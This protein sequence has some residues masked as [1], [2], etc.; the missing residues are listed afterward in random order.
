MGQIIEGEGEFFIYSAHDKK[1]IGPVNR[2]GRTIWPGDILY[3][4]DK[5]SAQINI[6]W[7]GHGRMTIFPGAMVIFPTPDERGIIVKGAIWIWEA[8][9]K[10]GESPGEIIG[11]SSA[12]VV[13]GTNFIMEVDDNNGVD[14]YT[15]KEG[16]VEVTS[17][18]NPSD[19]RI[20]NEGESVKVTAAGIADNPYDWDARIEE[21]SLD[22]YDLSETPEVEPFDPIDPDA[23]NPTEIAYTGDL[24]GELEGPSGDIAVEDQNLERDDAVKRLETT[25]GSPETPNLI[26][27]DS[28]ESEDINWGGVLLVL[29]IIVA[30]GLTYK[31]MRK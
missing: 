24:V 26:T 8:I 4:T 9:Q 19:N 2:G 10:L 31:K 16:I 27:E 1:W 3:A 23:V 13:R 6:R 28:G 11:S 14:T 29:I 7:K 22:D 30:V 17:I 21:Y 5:G 15:V 20:L 25:S 12:G 18:N